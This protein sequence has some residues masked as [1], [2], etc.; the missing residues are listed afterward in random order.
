LDIYEKTGLAFF[1]DFVSYYKIGNGWIEKEMARSV[2]LMN[3][4]NKRLT[5]PVQ[6]HTHTVKWTS[7]GYF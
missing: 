3:S 5:G 4:E 6:T 2:F 7:F 1:G